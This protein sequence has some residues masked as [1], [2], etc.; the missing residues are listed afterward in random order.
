LKED[1]TAK[2]GDFGVA[3]IQ[4]AAKLTKTGYFVGTPQYM[5]PEQLQAKAVDG[6][7]DQFSLAVMAYEMFAGNPPFTGESMIYQII[8]ADPP[9]FN[10]RLD[11]VLGKALSKKPEDR[12]ATCSEF[13]QAL[14]VALAS[15]AAAPARPPKWKF[16]ATM[17]GIFAFIGIAAFGARVL[18]NSALDRE[19][20]NRVQTPPSLATEIPAAPANPVP[21]PPAATEPA[22][23]KKQQP[24]ASKPM[25]QSRPPQPLPAQRSGPAG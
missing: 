5:S 14:D 13:V 20:Q 2:I 25:T 22:R 4:N 12:Y 11:P 7:A 19:A 24:A 10:V 8:T 16:A 21:P 18:L 9:A 17:A 3:R 6:R 23:Q 15:S 1:G